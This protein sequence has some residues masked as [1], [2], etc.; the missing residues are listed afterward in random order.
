MLAVT[1]ASVCALYPDLG[2]GSAARAP[3]A[4]GPTQG[5]QFTQLDESALVAAA[6]LP[7]TSA[8]E[9]GS[10]FDAPAPFIETSDSSVTQ[11]LT[12]PLGAPDPV[13]FLGPAPAPPGALADTGHAGKV[14]NL[15]HW[16]PE[17]SWYGPGFYGHRTACGYALTMDL[18]GVAHRTL[19]CG[20][21]VQFRW[22]GRT[23]SAPVVDR[24]PYVTGRIFDMT[25]G[26]CALLGHCFT[27]PIQYRIP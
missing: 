23:V 27:G 20:T 6:T 12:V 7:A 19:P 18:V 1:L 10:V 9:I 16:D 11:A 8:S 13:P 21:I 14:V 15:W 26:L 4:T 17:I 2:R 24:G 22:N 5:A 25:Y 3:Q